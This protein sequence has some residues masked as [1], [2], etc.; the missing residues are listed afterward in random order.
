MPSVYRLGLSEASLCYTCMGKCLPAAGEFCGILQACCQQSL[1]WPNPTG[2]YWSHMCFKHWETWRWLRTTICWVNDY[3]DSFMTVINNGAFQGISTLTFTAV[4]LVKLCSLSYCSI[5]R[6]FLVVLL[7][8]C[9]DMFY[10]RTFQVKV[11]FSL[12]V[13]PTAAVIQEFMTMMAICHTAVPECTDGT[14]IY[15]AASPGRSHLHEHS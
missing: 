8:F 3:L 14:I 11:P 1:V 13:Q 10:S 12:P 15:Q 2:E 6:V 4:C 7:L 5:I 9:C